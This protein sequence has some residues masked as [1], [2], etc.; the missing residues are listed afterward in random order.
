MKIKLAF[1]SDSQ[2]PPISSSYAGGAVWFPLK[3]AAADISSGFRVVAV[4]HFADSDALRIDHLL[5]WIHVDALG[6]WIGH[7]FVRGWNS[8]QFVDYRAR[9][10][11]SRHVTGCTAQGGSRLGFL[12][13]IFL[14]V[15]IISF[16][17]IVVF[18]HFLYLFCFGE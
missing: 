17:V 5:H 6:S 15:D 8:L 16:C 4:G 18:I 13:L 3:A 12:S 1:R 9:H 10:S 2:H 11:L 14:P 7:G